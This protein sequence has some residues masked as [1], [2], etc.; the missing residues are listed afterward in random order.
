[1]SASDPRLAGRAQSSFLPEMYMQAH[2]G[3][4]HAA[5]PIQE[6]FLNVRYPCSC[7]HL[8]NKGQE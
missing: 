1:M 8:W 5:N 3:L 2:V 6:T 7:E 4:Y